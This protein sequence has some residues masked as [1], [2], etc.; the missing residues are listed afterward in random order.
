MP[1]YCLMGHVDP[2][3]LEEYRE[4]HRA[5]WPELLEALRDAGWHNYS[6]CLRSDGTLIGYVEA[7]DLEQAQTRIAQTA[8]NARWQAEMSKL[9]ASEGPPDEAWEIIPEVFHLES[10]LPPRR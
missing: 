8:V 4:V 3:R 1:R 5:V 9:F 6:L 7:E 2:A 10:Q